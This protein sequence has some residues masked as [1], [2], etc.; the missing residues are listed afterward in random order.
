MIRTGRVGFLASEI[1]CRLLGSGRVRG[2]VPARSREP[3]PE[4]HSSIYPVV[5][6][7]Q[8]FIDAIVALR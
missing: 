2:V 1:V 7:P 3:D 6:A 4:R 5:Y 8:Q